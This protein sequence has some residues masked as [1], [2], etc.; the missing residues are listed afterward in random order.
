MVTTGTKPANPFTTIALHEAVFDSYTKDEMEFIFG[1]GGRY[2][3]I[4]N[5]SRVLTKSP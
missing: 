5:E 3:D 1:T 4:L 2:V